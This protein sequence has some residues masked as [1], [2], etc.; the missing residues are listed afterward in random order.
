MEGEVFKR[1]KEEILLLK[2]LNNTGHLWIGRIIRHNEFVGNVLEGAISGKKAVGRS[3][4][5]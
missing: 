2:I 3:R 5:Q 1:V 4:L